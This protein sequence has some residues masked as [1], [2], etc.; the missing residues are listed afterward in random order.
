MMLV[1]EPMVITAQFFVGKR[2]VT[3]A[4]PLK[5]GEDAGITLM[6]FFDQQNIPIPL[7]IPI[8]CCTSALLEEESAQEHERFQEPC[9]NL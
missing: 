5:S 7:Q 3:A 1:P 8:M 2:F 9:I 4:I 6:K